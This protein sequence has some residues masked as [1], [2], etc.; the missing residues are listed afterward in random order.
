MRAESEV[1][2][3]LQTL[4][5]SPGYAHVIAYFC[6]RD[7]SVVYDKEIT[8]QNL[9]RQFSTERLIRTEVSTLIGLMSKVALTLALPHP[10]SMQM[11]IDRT[12]TLLQE[13]HDILAAPLRVPTET[14]QPLIDEIPTAASGDMLREP[15][16][17]RE[18]LRT[19]ISFESLLSSATCETLHGSKTTRDSPS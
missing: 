12:E 8:P 4:C 18:S 17:I 7:S 3:E 9:T 13:M 6:Q 5:A 19:N 2:A 1:F 15:I 10:D 16:F 14:P 11:M